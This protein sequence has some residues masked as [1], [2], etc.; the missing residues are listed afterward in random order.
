MIS[1]NV[2]EKRENKWVYISSA[3]SVCSAG[4]ALPLSDI[5]LSDLLKLLLEKIKY[6]I[7]KKVSVLF[8]L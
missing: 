8:N 6:E 5:K 7:H 4:M 1:I 3:E 2:E